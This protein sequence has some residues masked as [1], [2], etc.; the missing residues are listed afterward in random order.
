LCGFPQNNESVANISR[1]SLPST[2][3][4]VGRVLKE[5]E[6]DES[7]AQS[8]D[9]TTFPVERFGIYWAWP[10]TLWVGEGFGA[11]FIDPLDLVSSLQGS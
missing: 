3:S 5:E 10:M 9:A 2:V 4:S 7:L 1:L 11:L 6:N 8:G